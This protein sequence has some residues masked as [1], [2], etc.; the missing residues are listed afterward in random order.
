MIFANYCK[1]IVGALIARP[2]NQREF[3]V[4]T[5]TT[6]GRPYKSNPF[7]HFSSFNIFYAIA[8]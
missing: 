5:R 4:F 1:L 8:I 2:Q 3:S 7:H 6:S